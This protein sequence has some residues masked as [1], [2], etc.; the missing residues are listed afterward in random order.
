M[1]EGGLI[2]WQAVVPGVI[3]LAA[4]AVFTALCLHF[5]IEWAVESVGTKVNGAKVELDGVDI[6]WTK[7]SITFRRL[8]V[9]DKGAPMTNLF[10]VKS[11]S[12]TVEP[13]PLLWAKVIIS[14]GAIEGIQTGTPRKSSG[15]VPPDP[16]DPE[17]RAEAAEQQQ[18]K[19]GQG[20][21]DGLKAKFDPDKIKAEDLASYRKVG[22]EKERIGRLAETWDKTADSIQVEGKTAEAKALFDRIKSTSYSGAAGAKKAQEDL[23]AVQKIS[24]E[25]KASASAVSSA[26]NSITAEAAGAKK[27]ISEIDQLKKQDIDGILAKYGISAFSTEGITRAVIGE[28]WFGRIDQAFYWFRRIRAMMPAKAKKKEKAAAPV[29]GGRNVPFKFRYAWPT[30][31]LKKANITGVTSGENP[32]SYEGTLADVTSDPRM[33][34]RPIVL[35]VAGSGKGGRSLSLKAVLDYTED[36]ARES[37]NLAYSGMSLDNV[38]MGDYNGPVGIGSGT[39]KVTV[40]LKTGGETVSGNVNFNGEPVAMRHDV[41]KAKAGDKVVSTV[42]NAITGV[43][44]LA[45]QVEVSGKLSKPAFKVKSSLDSA[46]KDALGAAA[47]KEADAARASAE[48]KVNGL[49][50][51]EKGKLSSLVEGNS[52]KA[53]SK[54]GV[55]QSQVD[56]AMKQADQVIAD[57][58]KKASAGALK[59]LPGLKK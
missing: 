54:L 41:D 7:G 13:K 47:K 1:K 22:E 15:A 19:E 27:T 52:S 30:F 33:V 45:V 48:K 14:K 38:K 56:S 11:M 10:E 3:V 20:I 46:F 28:E 55:K 26:K 17:G 24:G 2:R 6:G 36:I 4:V 57:L 8:Q 51:G 39:G 12:F 58:K 44:K 53:L 5:T 40:A 37:V 43:K 23:K 18:K 49:V 16:D 21:A 59:S 29:R 25:L 35:S 9:T 42:H 34:G 31:H 32:I 50:D